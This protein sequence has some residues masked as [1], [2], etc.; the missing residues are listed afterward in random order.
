MKFQPVIVFVAV[1]LFAPFLD[2]QTPAFVYQGQL[3]SNSVPANGVF[4]LRFRLVDVN[5]NTISGPVTNAPVGVTNG[6]FSTTL[7]FGS[8]PFT[9]ADRWLELGVRNYGNTNAYTVLGPLQPITSVPYAIRSLTALNASNLTTVLPIANLPTN[10]TLLTSN[11]VFSGSNVFNGV[12]T[13]TNGSNNISGIFAGAFSG[14]GSGL[15]NLSAATLTGTINDARLSTN[16]V[17]QNDTSVNFAG[18]VTATNFIGAGH[19]LTNVP[20]AFFWVTSTATNVQS[21]PNVGYICLNETNPVIVTLPSSPGVGDTFKVAGIGAGGWIIAQNAGQSIPSGNLSGSVGLVW[22]TNGPTGNWTGIA[23]S[24]DGAKLAATIA[25]GNIFVSTNFGATW[26]PQASSQPW[27]SVA[28]SADGVKMIASVGFTA[29]STGGKGA[30]WRSTDSGATWTTLLATSTNWSAVSS[31][32]DGARLLAVARTGAINFSTNSGASWLVVSG[33]GTTFLWRGCASSADGSDLVAVGENGSIVGSSNGGANWV[34]RT[35][36]SPVQLTSVT[37]S[38]DG[39]RQ[40]VTGNNGQVYLSTDAGTNWALVTTLAS[41]LIAVASSADG[42]R[43]AAAGGN[44]GVSGN[45]YGSMDSGVIWS[46]LPAAPVLSWSSIAASDDGSFL[47][48][49]VF[50]GNIYFSSQN[51]TTTGTGGYLFGAQHSAIELIYTG[52]GVFLPLNHEGTIRAY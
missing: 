2:A 36:F 26:A 45:L 35:N 50:G 7:N 22:R 6:L 44:A 10:V 21:F 30:I 15:T 3:S 29:N 47:A 42:F 23:C 13:A 41:Q 1:L 20:G 19:G 25:T 12:V 28:M 46:F 38:S 8:L 51:T 39:V 5:T 4:D 34:Q 9:G 11:Q 17:L 31:S 33:S 27:S 40:V 48:A 16:V 37:I 49:T 18:S 14:N 32:A 24:G 43:V 52:N